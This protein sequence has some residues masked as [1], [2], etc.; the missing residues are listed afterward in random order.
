MT[1]GADYAKNPVRGNYPFRPWIDQQLSA[2]S[3]Y[4]QLLTTWNRSVNLTAIENP[5]EIVARHFGE[6]IFA[7]S[8]VSG[9]LLHF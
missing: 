6:S 1:I 8:V 4:V 3:C 7:A 5:M 9:V 2:I